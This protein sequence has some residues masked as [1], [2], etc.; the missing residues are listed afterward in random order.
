MEIIE[1]SL[2]ILN[3]HPHPMQ[4][5]GVFL[6]VFIGISGII[7]MIF[8]E[9]LK[10]RNI[11]KSTKEP[12]D[13][14][15]LAGTISICILFFYLVCVKFLNI[16]AVLFKNEDLQLEEMHDYPLYNTYTTFSISIIALTLFLIGF[17]PYLLKINS[18]QISKKY[19]LDLIF[20]IFSVLFISASF[21]LHIHY[22]YEEIGEFSTSSYNDPYVD[23]Q[24][25]QVQGSILGT[26]SMLLVAIFIF[27][28]TIILNKKL[29]IISDNNG[30]L[31]K[32]YSHYTVFIIVIINQI[33]FITSTI[34]HQ[35][36]YTKFYYTIR[37]FYFV[38]TIIQIIQF[39]SL[40][41]FFVELTVKIKQIAVMISIENEF[42]EQKIKGPIVDLD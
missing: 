14:L 5:Y 12:F 17:I 19:R 13:K 41:A 42:D 38:Y 2:Q 35:I 34:F 15:L 4:V 24:F 8:F 32:F 23:D 6:L 21:I 27:I 36:S 11:K 39:L 10:E 16:L 30:K 26:A 22:R 18:Y 29:K 9:L 1:E 20:L 25:F 7:T 40:I 31:P 33:I 37:S 28:S 3:I